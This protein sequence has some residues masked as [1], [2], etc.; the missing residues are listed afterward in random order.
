MSVQ[1]QKRRIFRLSVQAAFVASLGWSVAQ[2]AVATADEGQMVISHV[3]STDGAISAYIDLA[4][5]RSM[6]FRKLVAAI[7]VSD[8]IVY[9]EPGTCGHGTRACL[10]VWMG[11]SGA[12]RFLRVIVDRRKADSDTDFMGSIGH[13]L[14]H[15]VEALSEPATISSVDL[16]NF[17][18]RIALTSMS[19]F[20]TTAAVS[21]GDAVRAELRA[22]RT[23]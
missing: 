21:A 4:A 13:E 19:R 7:E 8:G 2:P 16:Y 12:N 18:S 6:T 20:E 23:R 10:K 22:R 17:F 1:P 11:A 14:Q 5:T 9:V 3:R 15:T